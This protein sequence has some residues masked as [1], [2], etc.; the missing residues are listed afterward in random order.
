MALSAFGILM[1]IAGSAQAQT[2][3]FG[4]Y[5]EST[6]T[7]GSDAPF[8]AQGSQSLEQTLPGAVGQVI[9]VFLGLI[10]VVLLIIMVYAGFLWL[11]AGGNDE[12][13][14]RAKK[15]IRNGVIGLIIALSAFVITSFVVTQIQGALSGT[16]GGGAPSPQGQ[17]GGQ[18]G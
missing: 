14:A 18:G 8:Q 13:V 11:T 9:S 5:L 15:L 4:R 17:P 3:G 10:G 2:S 7:S 6:F 16:A 12:Q 1:L